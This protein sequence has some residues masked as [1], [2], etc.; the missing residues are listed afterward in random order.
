MFGFLSESGTETFMD[1]HGM[2]RCSAFDGKSTG[3]GS[4]GSAGSAGAGSSTSNG[5]S[6]G[7]VSKNDDIME[8]FEAMKQ[9]YQSMQPR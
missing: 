4:A 6:S 1:D 9:N 2:S 8:K 7:R 3:A 5:L